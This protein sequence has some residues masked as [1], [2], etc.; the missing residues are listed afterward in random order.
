MKESPLRGFFNRIFQQLARAVP[1]ATSLRVALHRK[2][3][4]RIGKNVWIGYDVVLDTSRPF[5]ITLE[6]NCVLSLR[7]TVL[8]HFREVQGVTIERDAFVGAGA[9]ILP[10]VVIGEGAVVAAGSVVTRSVAPF[11][12][13]QGNPAVPVAQCGVPLGRAE[14]MKE[15]SRSLRPISTRV[16][17]AGSSSPAEMTLKGE[18]GRP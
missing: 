12:M 3:G 14:T 6:D 7:V 11:T 9:L 1:G 15:F 16:S 10:G 5:A 8:A 18:E 2:R 4:V 17:K 13:V